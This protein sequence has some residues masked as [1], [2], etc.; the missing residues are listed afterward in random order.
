VSKLHL[1]PNLSLPIEAVTQTFAILA[2]RGMGK[3]YT[4]SVMAEEMLKAGQHVVFI[5]PTGGAW[6]LRSSYPIVILGGEHA[7]VPLEESAGE[8]IAT[9][10]AENGFSAVLDLSLFR[11][12]QLIRFMVAFAE[13]L[14]RLNRQALHLFVDEAD[15]VAPQ[16]RTYGGEENRMLG[17]MED[18]VRRGRLRG[19]GCT[20]ITQRPAVLNKNVLTQCESLFV[21]RLVHPKDIDAMMEWV[22]VHASSEEAE[23]VR[24]ELPTL[25]IGTAW[26][27]SPGWMQTLKR[28]EIRQR[29]TFDSSATP[30]PGEKARA[31]KHLA[32]IDLGALGAQIQATV[33]KSKDND[34][35]EL[36]RRVAEL[37][38]QLRDRPATVETKIERV[39][40]E[41]P[42]LKNGQLDKALKLVDRLGEIAAPLKQAIDRVAKPSIP[43][44]TKPAPAAVVPARKPHHVPEK[45]QPSRSIASSTEGDMTGPE[46]RI[47]DAIAWLESLGIEQPDQ[48]AVAFLAGYTF[49]GGAFNNPRGRLRS[50]GL[51]D[52]P[53]G[54]RI[55]LTEAG[56]TLSVAPETPLNTE[57]LHRHVMARLP[58]PEQRILQPLL[59]AYPES[60]SNDELAE[61]AG[62]TAG[63][64][65]FNNPRGRLRSLGLIDYPSPGRVVAKS[66]LFLS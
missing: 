42:V 40:I 2:K 11:K 21:L 38:R 15:A 57:E 5:D 35:R 7:D 32:E 59:D 36:R 9:A 27:W 53:G 25:P 41:V 65:A 17:A 22:N 24:A 8:V 45:V 39:E 43:S 61:A 14:Y 49:G 28:V 30:K 55:A 37:E 66:L 48:A 46:Q 29:E 44:S 12:G 18:I 52:Y 33:Q 3:S 13:A 58:G 60:L 19:L 62:Y 50:R 4:A 23:K 51:V 56:R 31:P 47:L 34:P 1:A 54:E 20:L 26:F 16:G 6:G 63:A 10:I 64:G